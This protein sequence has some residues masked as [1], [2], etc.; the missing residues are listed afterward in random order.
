M[1]LKTGPH[2]IWNNC[3]WGKASA[4]KT[5]TSTK[6]ESQVYGE[7]S[8]KNNSGWCQFQR[9]VDSLSALETENGRNSHRCNGNMGLETYHKEQWHHV[10]STLLL[11]SYVLQFKMDGWMKQ[12]SYSAKCAFWDE[13]YPMISYTSCLQKA[14]V[15]TQDKPSK[16]CTHVVYIQL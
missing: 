7:F 14:E 16:V 5:I 9:N 3:C 11:S 2:G 8:W 13:I 10:F 6:K 1:F 12:P 15:V 4:E